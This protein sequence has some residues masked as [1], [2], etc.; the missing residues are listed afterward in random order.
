M[1]ITQKCEWPRCA[2]KVKGET[3]TSA[4]NFLQLHDAQA[5]SIANKPEKPRRPILAM[6]GD[7]LDYK[8]T[9]KSMCSR[10]STKKP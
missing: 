8:K 6:L 5:H 7:T 3:E 2:K 4:F 1:T 10:K 9:E